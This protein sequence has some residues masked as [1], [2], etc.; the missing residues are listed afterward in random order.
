MITDPAGAIEYVNPKFVEVTG[1]TVEEALGQNPRVL[2]SG[3]QPKE[4]Y[5]ALWQTISAGNDWHGEFCNK[6]KNGDIYWESASISPIRDSQGQIVHFVAIKEDIT[7]RKQSELSL[8][9][10]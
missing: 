6:K 1:Y 3:D 9:H 10:I 7:E 4:F 2:N 5:Q 8:I